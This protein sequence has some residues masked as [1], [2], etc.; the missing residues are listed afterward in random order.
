MKRIV[1]APNGKDLPAAIVLVLIV[2]AIAG[3]TAWIYQLAHGMQATGLG[4]QIVWGMYIAGFFTAAGGGAALLAMVSVNAIRPILP[5]SANRKLALLALASFLSAGVMIAMDVGY[6]IHLW[7]MIIAGRWTSLMTWDFWMLNLSLVMAIAQLFAARIAIIR[8][9]VAILSLLSASMLVV[10]E[11]WMLSSMEARAFWAGGQLI[12]GFLFGAGVSGLGLAV[13]TLPTDS[14]D[15]LR[16]WLKLLLGINIILVFAE[17]MNA[18][19][20]RIP[21]GSLFCLHLVVG[22]VIPFVLLF[23]QKKFGIRAA[24]VLVVFGVFVDKIRLLSVGQAH[25]SLALPA[26]SYYPSSVE[27]LAVMGAVAIGVLLYFGV[28]QIYRSE[29]ELK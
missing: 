8:Y 23:F 17:M 28:Q 26:G 22:L 27:T 25:P 2:P 13:F 19:V 6:P 12:A 14:T 16:R 21:I 4:Q 9:I 20:K 18:L 11:G 24:A 29:V 3:L 15:I 7:K 1:S 10:V 5:A